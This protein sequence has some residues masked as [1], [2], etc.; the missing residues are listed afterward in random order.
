[1][2]VIVVVYNA[3]DHLAR[4]LASLEAQTFG[5]FEAIVC[6]NASTDGA[7]ETARASATDPRFRFHVFGSNLGFA[8]AN[9]RAAGMARGLWLALLNPDAIA[10]PD[11]LERLLAAARRHPDCDVF[12]SLQLD[13]ADPGRMDGAGDVLSAWGVPWRG[14]FGHR[15]VALAEGECFSACGAAAFYR[16]ERFRVLSG[17]AETFF[18][19]CE[20]VDLGFRHRLAGG[21]AIFVPDAVVQHWGGASTGRRSD[22]AIYH[23]ARNRLWTFLRCMPGALLVALLLPHLAATLILLV[24]AAPRGG[25]AAFLRG[26]KDAVAALPAILAERRRIQATRCASPWGIAAALTWS[27][28]AAIRRA[29]SIRPL[30]RDGTVSRRQPAPRI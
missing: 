27:L 28:L 20:D 4:C 30:V 25:A 6:D 17:F 8:A 12:A 22:F 23:G 7:F 9:N 10:A 14:G 19:F 1:M 29:P 26:I 3:G 18:C 21:H 13:A 2:T 5:A 15:R 11:W 24:L 16:A